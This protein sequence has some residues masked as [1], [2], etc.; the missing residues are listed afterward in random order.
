MIYITESAC[1]GKDDGLSVCSIGEDGGSSSREL[2]DQY[3]WKF[4]QEFLREG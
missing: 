2:F 4:M 1:S 3:S